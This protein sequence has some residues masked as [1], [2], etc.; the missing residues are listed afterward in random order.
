MPSVL[1]GGLAAHGRR[2]G[3]PPLEFLR[4]LACVDRRLRPV[5]TGDC[6]SFETVRGRRL[7]PPPLLHADA[8]DEVERCAR[9]TTCR[10]PGPAGWSSVLD[11]LAASGRLS[12][13][14]R[15]IYVTE[16]AYETKPPDPGARYTPARRRRAMAF[17]E[18]LAAREPRVRSFAQFLVRDL[19][20]TGLRP[21]GDAAQLAVGPAVRRPAAEAARVRAARA[22]ARGAGGPAVRAGVGA[23]A[24]GGGRAPGAGAEPPAERAPGATMV[25]G[26]TDRRGVVERGAAGARGHR[27]P[28]RPARAGALGVRAGGEAALGGP[29]ALRVVA[30]HLL[31][32]I[33]R[34]SRWRR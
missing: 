10:W 26:R 27:V 15:A 14:L 25:S 5:E 4:E 17:A 31:H 7:R 24:A 11:R 8:P 28:D 3:I 6:A 9:P 20:G 22:A 2:D 19:H 13:R 34:S 23:R 18:A 16:Y 29:P 21:A 33:P 32:L 30:L 12:P 1:V